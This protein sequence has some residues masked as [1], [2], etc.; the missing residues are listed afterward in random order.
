MYTENI[1]NLNRILITSLS[2]LENMTIHLP[3]Q[4]AP[5]FPS[6]SD[7]IRR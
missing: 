4:N 2:V 3:K 6:E 1:Q 5:S 7:L